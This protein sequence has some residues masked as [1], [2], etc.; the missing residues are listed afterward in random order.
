MPGCSSTQA[1]LSWETKPM[2]KYVP[3]TLEGTAHDDG[4]QMESIERRTSDT[5][6]R[7]MTVLPDEGRAAGADDLYTVVSDSGKAYLVDAREGTCECPDHQ[8]RTPSGGCIHQRRV[9]FATGQQATPASVDG[10]DE[11][12]GELVDVTLRVAATDGGIIV[13]D[14]DG[15]VLD[16][17]SKRPDDCLCWDIDGG[18]PCWGCFREGFD[19][20]N[21]AE[22][23]AD[24]DGGD[25]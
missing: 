18:L 23:A 1:G 7:C 5:L 12:L 22:P 3:R 8:Y 11:R 14:D 19:S 17:G 2:R 25:R 13:A 10:V 6:T 24:E 15:E 16:D 21:P 20:Q 4:S 9:A